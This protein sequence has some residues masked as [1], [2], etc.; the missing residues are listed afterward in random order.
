MPDSV[1]A[2]DFSAPVAV[3]V[4]PSGD[5]TGATDPGTIQSLLNAGVP[6]QLTRG[7]YYLDTP[8]VL[9]PSQYVSLSGV[10]SSFQYPITGYETILKAVA[11]MTYGVIN[12]PNAGTG[13]PGG[14]LYDFTIN[15]NQQCPNGL[16]VNIASGAAQHWNVTNVSAGN[17]T[18][19][20][21]NLTNA[22]EWNF[23]NCGDDNLQWGSPS[24][25]SVLYNAPSDF[26]IFN[27]CQFSGAFTGGAAG[28]YLFDSTLSSLGTTSSWT[29]LQVVGG[30]IYDTATA[31]AVNINAVS[32]T[33]I[34]VQFNIN[35]QA[36]GIRGSR[37]VPSGGGANH[38][39]F[40]DCVYFI[41]QTASSGIT[42]FEPASS[43]AV[44][45]YR[46]IGAFYFSSTGYTGAIT[47]FIANS[48]AS[49]FTREGFGF[50]PLAG[51]T[52]VQSNA[53]AALTNPPI[54]GTAYQN[55]TGQDVDFYVPVSFAASTASTFVWA[56]GPTSAY[57]LNVY[58]DTEPSA[59]TGAKTTT[60]RARIP[61]GWFYKL[62]VTGAGTT[63]GTGFIVPA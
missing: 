16:Y 11:A 13:N 63:V 2:S 23:Q 25:L 60:Y 46:V 54:S 52:L 50:L 6:V 35:N 41:T 8:L 7:T 61:A 9:P 58:N 15:A 33:F 20:S 31:V 3:T 57:G 62:T 44:S 38:M 48:S 47:E 10:G 29:I 18:S 22:C 34:G 49:T 40:I 39:A 4:Y 56:M 1:Y 55:T 43:T 27:G 51:A 24:G 37:P 17:G 12:Y 19:Y 53:V 28:L 42:I 30:Q 32:A 21:F 36:I 5:A 14:A 26:G 45:H 59:I